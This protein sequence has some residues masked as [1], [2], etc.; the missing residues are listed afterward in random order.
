MSINIRMCFPLKLIFFG[1]P[2]IDKR[3]RNDIETA[4]YTYRLKTPRECS[5]DTGG[6]I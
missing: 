5:P 4:T 6:H 1:N 2:T 3:V